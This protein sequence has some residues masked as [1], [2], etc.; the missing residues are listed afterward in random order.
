[1]AH[2]GPSPTV[3]VCLT[4]S[5]VDTTGA[6]LAQADLKTFTALGTYGAIIA[7]GV[8]AD[9]FTGHDHSQSVPESLLRETLEKI[10]DCFTVSAVKVGMVPTP[11]QIRVVGRW[12]RAHP[13]IPVVIDPVLTDQV[14]IPQMAPEVILAMQGELL[15]RAALITPNRFEAAQLAG[16]EEV[17]IEEDMI[18]V[19]K[20]LFNTYGCQT[21]VTGGGLGETSLDVF[22][23]MDGVRRFTAP[24]V[25]MADGKVVG[26][27]CT[28]AAAITAQLAR[29]ESMRESIQAAKSY[30]LALIRATAPL[31]TDNLA[32]PLCHFMAVDSLAQ[33]DGVGI[34][35]AS[36]SDRLQIPKTDRHQRR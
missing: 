17:L 13:T 23:G 11:G 22:A 24:A 35:A 28:Y 2:S 30:V 36:S 10:D 3:P 6:T 1:M 9:S 8:L 16:F 31:C 4:I 20:Q 34:S 15:P 32:H 25:T 18:T 29:G 21:V 5:A 26:A 33:A 27:G 19:A 14:G 7:T 12:L